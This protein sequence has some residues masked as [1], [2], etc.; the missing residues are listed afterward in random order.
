[1]IFVCVQAEASA[2]AQMAAVFN[3]HGLDDRGIFQVGC[4]FRIQHISRYFSS[5]LLVVWFYLLLVFRFE[6]C[7]IFFCTYF[8]ILLFSCQGM[9]ESLRQ[10][11][12]TD[13]PR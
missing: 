3:E 6:H 9:A 8:R 10:D 1:M 13:S 2:A 12:G 5:R 4:A 11:N 7:F